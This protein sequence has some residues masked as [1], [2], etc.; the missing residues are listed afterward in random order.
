MSD[1]VLGM[2]EPETEDERVAFWR[3]LVL[4]HAGYPRSL[5]RQLVNGG[6]DVH[7]ATKLLGDGCPPQLAVRIL[8]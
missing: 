6:A 8:L 2:S 5:S 4:V 3:F 1:Y 7:A